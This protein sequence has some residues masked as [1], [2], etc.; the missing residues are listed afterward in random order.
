MNII[1]FLSL[2]LSLPI[3][4]LWDFIICLIIGEVALRIAFEKAGEWGNS[5]SE[6]YFLHWII[7]ILV[8]FALWILVCGLICFVRFTKAHWL[9]VLIITCS[10]LGTGI[11][12]VIFY[13][14]RKRNRVAIQN[15]K[16]SR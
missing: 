13:R 3:D 2:P 4:P 16:K 1:D 8:W 5:S 9:M 14:C 7:R 12:A 15:V 11:T 10:V 6:R